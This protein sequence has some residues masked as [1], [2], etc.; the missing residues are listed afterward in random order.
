[1]LFFKHHKAEETAL[2]PISAPEPIEEEEV[3]TYSK[4]T[5]F[6]PGGVR[7]FEKAEDWETTEGLEIQF[8]QDGVSYTI[9]GCPY[10]VED[11]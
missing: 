2:R 10:L 5:I 1:M 8:D 4:I 3:T 7:V 9:G 11:S 6:F